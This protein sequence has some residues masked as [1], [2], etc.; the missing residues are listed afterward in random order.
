MK[1]KV[2]LV[3]STFHLF[4]CPMNIPSKRSSLISPVGLHLPGAPAHTEA[5][6]SPAQP[7][8]GELLE[9]EVWAG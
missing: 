5:I 6:F 8:L 3:L 4:V 7:S 9:E 2:V 1:L